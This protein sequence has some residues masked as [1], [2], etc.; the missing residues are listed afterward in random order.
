M[1]PTGSAEE[2]FLTQNVQQYCNSTS[3]TTSN[4]GSCPASGYTS[5]RFTR[6]TNCGQPQGCGQIS[7]WG[8]VSPLV[9]VDGICK[10]SPANQAQCPAGYDSFTCSCNPIP[11]PTPCE[12]NIGFCELGGWDICQECCVEYQ[13]GPCLGGSPIVIDVQGD[14]FSLTNASNGV[15][16]DLNA[17]GTRERL[18][19][20]AI[21]TDDAWLVLD[22]DNNG[23]IDNGSELF[24]N[25]TPQ[26]EPP[27][28]EQRNGFLAL[29][30][31]D[32]PENGGNSDGVISRQDAI[33]DSLRLWRDSDHNGRSR[34]SELFR[35]PELG[36]RKIH[37]DYQMSRRVDEFGNQFRW[38]A[39]VKDA[40]DAQL[41]RWAW[42][43][44]LVTQ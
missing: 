41:G 37:L 42:D 11:T 4:C 23:R 36:L 40:N 7:T 35:L 8:C 3:P 43:V 25:F 2:G 24:G 12:G 5:D 10:M 28:G 38:R 30:E 33:F 32:K 27:P 29:A 21:G 34:N 39:R 1:Q 26:P 14:G 19:W 44:I 31:Y 15:D 16:F 13:G 6:Y 22:R 20:T 18:G 17:D 9:D